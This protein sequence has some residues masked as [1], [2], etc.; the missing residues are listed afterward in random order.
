MPPE[1]QLPRVVVMVTHQD[2][3]K[4]LA[5]F[6]ASSPAEKDRAN[7]AV[8]TARRK[9][10]FT[11]PSPAEGYGRIPG[12]KVCSMLCGSGFGQDRRCAGMSA[13][14]RLN[15]GRR[16]LQQRKKALAHP[17]DRDAVNMRTDIERRDDRAIV[18][19][20]RDRD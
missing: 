7:R 8:P 10:G 11:A 13:Q 9:L 17:L 3:S 12:G 19:A 15:F 5:A 18:P 1:L 16:L 4:G 6:A 14:Q 20:H 2:P